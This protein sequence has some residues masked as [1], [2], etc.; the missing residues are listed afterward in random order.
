MSQ[1]IIGLDIGS[2]S[3][4]VVHLETSFRKF[5]WT[6][7]ARRTWPLV[8][9]DQAE[10]KQRLAL[11]AAM[12]EL[13]ELGELEGDV[14]VTALP[15]DRVISRVLHFP[16][17]NIS[18]IES[19]IG[20][21]LEGHVPYSVDEIV[22]DFHVL[23][24]GED[25]TRVFVAAVPREEFEA[26]L[27]FLETHGIDPQIV[28]FAGAA[29]ARLASLVTREEESVLLVDLGAE[30][31]EFSIVENGRLTGMRSLRR[32][33]R[34]LASAIA[35][36]QSIDFQ[37]AQAVMQ[38]EG[39][40][41]PEG[42]PYVEEGEEP[43]AAAAR[44]ALW[45]VVS[46]IHQ[47]LASR[48]ADGQA[49]ISRVFLSGG[50][51]GLRGICDYMEAHLEVP[52][53]P[54]SMT[55]F[56]FNELDDPFGVGSEVANALGLGMLSVSGGLGHVINFRR[57]QYAYQGDFEFLREKLFHV[58]A[59]VLLVAL[60]AGGKSY[61][62]YNTLVAERDAQVE[63][64]ERFSG[65]LFNESRDDFDTVLSL[66]LDIPEDG[67]SSVFPDITAKEVLYDV[68]EIMTEVRQ[69]SGADLQA[70]RG[71]GG[72]GLGESGNEEVPEGPV[73]PGS[74][75]SPGPSEDSARDGRTSAPT[76]PASRP[77]AAPVR[78]VQ[79]AANAPASLPVGVS[80]RGGVIQPPR[81]LQVLP[82]TNI[83]DRLLREKPSLGPAGEIVRPP[84]PQAEDAPEDDERAARLERLRAARAL[85]S[86]SL[87]PASRSRAGR[88]IPTL[89][90]LRGATVPAAALSPPG[91]REPAALSGR[92]ATPPPV[93]EGLQAEPVASGI[94]G[95]GDALP[96][97]GEE[98][99][100][101]LESIQIGQS[102]VDLKGE[103]S[104]LEASTL[105]EQRL[106]AHECFQNVVLE[107]TDKITF[108]RHRGWY[109][110]RISFD[111][112][113]TRE[114]RRDRQKGDR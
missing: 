3:I 99:F 86:T 65:E 94:E 71:Q 19:A 48:D 35:A 108:E 113:C 14:V 22:Y 32:G 21:E 80:P 33:G 36:A 91:A 20:F 29:A 95:E 18:Q 15:S 27:D 78:A 83:P 76:P 10:H 52:V 105:L 67:A 47:T 39:L 110:F 63:E 57:G 38:S 93:P 70:M 69:T 17:T 30:A 114:G 9:G 28:S 51:A 74:P 87:S 44:E 81:A 50:L 45:P 102:S 101:E 42:A 5:Q 55:D 77:L 56:E 26:Q 90:T 112:D 37:T 75:A 7:V 34:Q 111:L 64:L 88:G 6:H 106:G 12:E 109:N 96:T 8:T 66:L 104:V 103:A 62:R 59:M 13:L 82:G 85:R 100:V 79:P 46:R 4:T 16:F 60:M 107:G 25:G 84:G 49:P 68:T 41:V 53:E 61:M 43:L 98:I 40:V 72:D 24:Q 73:P 1:R 31:T 54:L 97:D 89:P 23:E 2:S 92:A 58:V 11:D